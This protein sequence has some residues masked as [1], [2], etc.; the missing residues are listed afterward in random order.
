MLPLQGS[1]SAALNIDEVD[2]Q[3]IGRQLNFTPDAFVAAYKDSLSA[4]SN[5]S[6]AL[7]IPIV[8]LGLAFRHACRYALRLHA[9]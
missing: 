3:F 1:K 5:Q 9:P 8:K 2:L 7:E 6:L 4:R